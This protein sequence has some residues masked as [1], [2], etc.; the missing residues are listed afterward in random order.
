MKNGPYHEWNSDNYKIISGNYLNGDK[1][2]KWILR[3]NDGT[4]KAEESYVNG[5]MDGKWLWYRPDGVKEKEGTNKNGLTH[6]LWSPWNNAHHK[7]DEKTYVNGNLDGAITIWHE[8][9]TKEREGIIRGNEPEG[10]WTYYNSDGTV[11]FRFDY[12]SGLDRVR[13][14]ELEERD[15]LFYKIGKNNSYTGIV[16]ESGGIKDYLLLGRFQMGRRDGQW[17]QW[18]RNGIKEV[19]F[20]RFS[21]LSINIF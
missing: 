1:H 4:L 7:K 14:A 10:N 19:E 21:E 18:H 6:G 5:E 11:D 16:V 15:G 20:S 2:G 8:D 12:G 13:I 17:V 9:G 3:N